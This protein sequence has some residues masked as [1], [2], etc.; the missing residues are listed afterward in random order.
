[1]RPVFLMMLFLAGCASGHEVGANVAYD[2]IPSTEPINFHH[3]EYRW[4]VVFVTP[5]RMQ[6][7]A[8]LL[9][10]PHR[11]RGLAM[12]RSD[13]NGLPM[14]S[15]TIYVRDDAPFEVL[16]HETRHCLG[17]HY[18]ERSFHLA[19][20]PPPTPEARQP[21]GGLPTTYPEP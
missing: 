7:L 3:Y 1:M 21:E 5:E 10:Q 8:K 16:I 11:A 13:E 12:W 18:H 14:Q 19:G 20:A 17:G 6:R 4:R 15:C 2:Q 9:R